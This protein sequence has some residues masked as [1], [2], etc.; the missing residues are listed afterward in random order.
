MKKWLQGIGIGALALGL[1]ACGSAAEPK[2]DPETG[3]KVEVTNKSDM[4]AQEVYSKAMEV[5]AEQKS[6][7]AVMDI[8][9]NMSIPSE[10]MN[11]DSKIKMDM[12]MIVDPMALHQTMSMDMGEMGA[13]DMELYMT[14]AGFFMHDAQMDQWIKMPN[15][16][17]EE[18][19]ASMGGET[20]PT[21][22]LQM[23]KDFKDDLKFEQ[24]DDEYIL[25]LN[26]SGDKLNNLVQKLIGDAMPIEG[27]MTEEEQ[28]V[29]D[30]MNVKSLDLTIYIDKKTF[31]TN[32]FDMDMDLTM[33]VEEEEMH[34]VQ[35]MKSVI[36]KINEI[37]EI[38]VP[39]EVLDEAVSLEDLMGEEG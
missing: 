31:Y 25:T 7:H 36:T 26:A 33:K 2:T 10:E 8:E 4:T 5:S 38:V 20:D 9:Q 16:M 29:Y 24:T 13:T 3:K 12:D 23:F 1:A 27:A 22:D 32:A 37:D 21:L 34:M 6:M 28:E 19:M 11:L 35:K 14:D 30:N 18:M 15:D 17:Y 39:K